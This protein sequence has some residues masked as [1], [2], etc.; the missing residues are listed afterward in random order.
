MLVPPIL[1]VPNLTTVVRL[2]IYD[3]LLG[4]M[5]P[6]FASAF[7]T[8]LMRQTFR[9][10]PRDFEDAAVIDGARLLAAAALR[11]AAAR[12]ARR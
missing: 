9:T 11:A 5:A 4:V 6:Y 2:G 12:E 10:I 8:F 3:T 7:G 1:I